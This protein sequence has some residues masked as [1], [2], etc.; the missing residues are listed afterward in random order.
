MNDQSNERLYY[1]ASRPPWREILSHRWSAAR[2]SSLVLRNAD[3]DYFLLGAPGETEDTGAYVPLPDESA[4]PGIGGSY[5]DVFRVDVTEHVD[6]Q[7]VGLPTVYGRESVE[8]W[9]AWWVRDPVRVVRAQT[10]HGWHMVRAHLTSVLRHLTE[11][12]E[13]AGS[14]LGAPEI[15]Q[16]LGVPQHLEETGLSYRVLDVRL[17]ETGEELRL[18]QDEGDGVRYSWTTSR[19]GEYE[20]CLQALRAGPASLAALW[21]LRHPDQVRQVLDWAVDH[22]RL[23]VPPRTDWQEE[24]AALLGTLTDQE[25]KEISYLLRDRLS[26]LGRPVPGVPL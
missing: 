6:I 7:A 4:A 15:M 22:E 26:A 1:R 16:H 23:L 11:A 12:Q 25:R 3:G 8:L 20:F 24:L 19:R 17:R 18:G 9:V 2:D 5:T 14:G 21:L 10:L 13:S